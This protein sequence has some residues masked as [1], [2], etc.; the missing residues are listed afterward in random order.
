[1]DDPV[2]QMNSQRI[3]ARL[4]QCVQPGRECGRGGARPATGAERCQTRV[5]GPP[6]LQHSFFPS[7]LNSW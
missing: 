1:M 2:K 5:S 3:Q 6:S 7:S 4:S